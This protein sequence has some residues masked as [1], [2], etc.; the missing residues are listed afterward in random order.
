MNPDSNP[1]NVNAGG[2]PPAAPAAHR[3]SSGEYTSNPFLISTKGL[4]L[5]LQ[6]NPVPVLLSGFV[7]VA[8]IIVLYILM[9]IT[10]LA[11]GSSPNVALLILFVLAMAVVGVVTVGAF[12]AIAAASARK[13]AIGTKEA[14]QRGFSKFFPLLGLTLLIVLMYI[15][16]GIV[17]GLLSTALR[18]VPAVGII[19]ALVGIVAIFYL[20]GRLMLAVVAMFE[21][22]LGPVKALKRSAELTKGHVMEMLGASFAGSLMASQGLLAIA[23]S[24]APLVGRYNELK[25]LKESGAPKPKMHWLNWGLPVLMIVLIGG[26]F[27]LITMAAVNSRDKLQN[28]N[29]YDFNNSQFESDFESDFN[30]FNSEDFDSSDFNSDFDSAE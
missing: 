22:D 2:V 25:S 10:G 8:A 4:V 9:M 24:L 11:G 30:N 15:G 13:E 23:A 1:V 28:T 29:P 16:G 17:F 20:S 21:E 18:S 7:G 3:A 27:A 12:L 26:Y 6:N 19:L 14:F 5:T